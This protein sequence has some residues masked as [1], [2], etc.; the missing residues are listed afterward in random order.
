MNSLTQKTWANW[1]RQYEYIAQGAII[2]S[3]INWYEHGEQSNKYFLNLANYK[4]KKMQYLVYKLVVAN[5][6]CTTDPKQIMTEIQNF[7]GSLYDAGSEQ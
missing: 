6:E 4:K 5:D 3:R 1:N 2:R 7:Y